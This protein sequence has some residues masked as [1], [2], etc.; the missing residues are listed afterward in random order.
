MFTIIM[1]PAHPHDGVDEEDHDADRVDG[2]DDSHRTTALSLWGHVAAETAPRHTGPH[3]TG[4]A[5]LGVKRYVN[6]GTEMTRVKREM[7]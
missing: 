1:T 2:H 7:L 5:G 6:I 4:T 3:A